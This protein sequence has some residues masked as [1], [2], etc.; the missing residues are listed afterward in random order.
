MNLS[1]KEKIQ[2]FKAAKKPRKEIRLKFEVI[3]NGIS[4][5]KVEHFEHRYKSSFK[6]NEVAKI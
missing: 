4:L 6:I 1:L 5:P 3:T 2:L